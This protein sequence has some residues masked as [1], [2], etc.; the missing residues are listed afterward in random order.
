MRPQTRLGAPLGNILKIV[1]FENYTNSV[2]KVKKKISKICI[3]ID[4]TIAFD[5]KLSIT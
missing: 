4:N 1:H 2:L 3:Q 5:N